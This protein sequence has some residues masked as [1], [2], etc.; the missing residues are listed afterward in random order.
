MTQLRN[1]QLQK[2]VREIQQFIDDK[3]K[4]A[5]APKARDWRTYEDEWDA[6]IR[7]AVE[8][9]EPLV[10][11]ACMNVIVR[12]GPGPAHVLDLRQRVLIILLQRWCDQSNRVMGCLL[13]L[14]GALNGTHVSYKT[15]ERLYSDEDVL[16]ALH[17]LH[18]LML[19]EKGIHV[20]DACGDATGYALTI[21]KHYATEATKRKEKAKTQDG[22]KK[23]V[24]AF[25]MLDINTGMYITHG[26]SFKSEKDAYD[27]AMQMLRTLDVKVRSIRLDR[28][29]SAQ[30]YVDQFPNSTVYIMPKKNV[31]LKGSWHWK[32]TLMRMYNDLMTYL[33]E[34]FKRN[35]SEN[36]FGTDKRLF[37]W[38]LPQ[39]RD[40]RIDT[41]SFVLTELHNLLHLSPKVA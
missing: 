21:T 16:L 23:F 19:E 20:V 15:V 24:Y 17:N 18:V 8:T 29:Y 30:H 2:K 3:Y 9:L 27:Q 36:G 13:A 1:K 26:T 41:A 37:G 32:R 35:H 33:E 4:P 6:R 14:F 12:K 7:Y 22:K 38:S 34:Y 28:Y 39:R 25:K 5:H 40:D 31:T 10:A 11:R